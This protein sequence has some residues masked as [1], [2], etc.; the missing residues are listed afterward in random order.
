MTRFE[1]SLRK[2]ELLIEK[3]RT[4]Q[5][6]I[7]ER[8]FYLDEKNK[9]IQESLQQLEK[10]KQKRVREEE[11]IRGTNNAFQ[12][13]R[14]LFITEKK[15]KQKQYRRMGKKKKPTLKGIG[16]KRPKMKKE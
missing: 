4:H 16:R 5:N 15:R 2:L 10:R 7:L 3:E 6:E 14:G 9:R 13:I 11:Q 12:C 1:K 8:I